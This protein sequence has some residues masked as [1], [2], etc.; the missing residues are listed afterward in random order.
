MFKIQ[1]YTALSSTQEKAKALA[2]KGVYNTI[3]VAET[4]TKGKGRFDRSWASG[5]GGLYCT[6][7]LKNPKVDISKL[8]YMTFV[9][10]LSIV[11]ALD[12]LQIKAKIKWPNDV[13]IDGKKVCGILSESMLGKEQFVLIG[14]GLN[15]NQ[16]K[17]PKMASRAPTSLLIETKKTFDTD[18]ILGKI[19]H[20]FERAYPLF[21]KGRFSM[22]RNLWKKN[23][24][25]LGKTIT[26]DTISKK[27]Q[28]IAVDIDEN[29]SLM[30]ETKDGKLE[31]ILEGDI[32]Y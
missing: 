11:K 8:P 21:Q 7:I 5:R 15:V 12:D 14:I 30:V 2:K 29:G 23:T 9:A 17:F 4:Q 28:G 3:V 18:K 13:L 19:A 25:T 1:Y 22:I 32:S 20:H 24:S 31:R 27:I 10:A 6:I 26:I 16:K